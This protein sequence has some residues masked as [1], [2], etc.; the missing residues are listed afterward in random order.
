MRS[1]FIIGAIF[2]LFGCSEQ[3]ENKVEP[4]KSDAENIA[5]EPS[6]S[7][8]V[9]V[10]SASDITQEEA[11]EFAKELQKK[12]HEDEQFLLDA[13]ELKEY[14]T[15]SNYVITDWHNYANKLHKYA[16]RAVAEY[17]Q[18]YFPNSDLINPYNVCDTAFRDLNLYAG[19]MMNI[20]REDTAIDRK[21]LRQEKEDYEKSKAKCDHRVSIGYVK[22]SEEYENE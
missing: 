2:L 3:V 4:I 16:P 11:E 5:S 13:F 10:K 8:P 21:I 15:L 7:S 6:I 12:I 18:V 20:A 9:T 22:A 19:A 14:E 1:L 17:G